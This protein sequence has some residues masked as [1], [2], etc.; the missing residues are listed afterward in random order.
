MKPALLVAFIWSVLIL[1]SA[2][3]ALAQDTNILFVGNSYTHGRYQPVLGYNAGAGSNP[4]DTVVHD[5][6]CPT[7]PCT[8]AEAGPQVTP[9]TSNTPGGTLT[10]QLNNLQAN[11]SSQYNE[12]GPYGGVAGIFLQFTKDAG[13]HYNVSLIAVSSATL[14]GYANN[15]GNEAGIL[16]LIESSQY[17]QVVLQDQSFQPLPTSINVNGQTVA[18]RGNPTSFAS[19][20]SK[21]VNGIDKADAL[22][23]KPNAAITSFKH[24]QSLPTDSPVAIRTRRSLAPARLHSKVV[25]RPMRLMSATSTQLRPWRPI[26]TMRM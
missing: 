26:C 8:G 2:N 23:G 25:T 18:T 3:Y 22:A 16:P 5:L 12:V 14:T 4:S 19:G 24:H 7:L 1:V 9:T 10:N 15:T 13:L 21:L 20:V 11:P 17:S 6:L